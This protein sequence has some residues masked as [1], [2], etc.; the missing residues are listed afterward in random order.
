MVIELSLTFAIIAL[1]IINTILTHLFNWAWRAAVEEPT[2]AGLVFIAEC[3][4]WIV[5]IVIIINI[6]T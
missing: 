5:V 6:T 3:I 1:V 4:R 2:F